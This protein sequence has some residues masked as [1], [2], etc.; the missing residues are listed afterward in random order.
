MDAE[1][2]I[3]VL[4]GGLVGSACTLAL[5]RQGLK[6]ALVERGSAQENIADETLDD[7]IYA[8]TPGNAAWLRSLDVWQKL[9]PRHVC[10]IDRMQVH[11]DSD[12]ASIDFDAD[13]AHVERLGYIVESKRLQQALWNALRE[14][15]AALLTDTVCAG[16]VWQAEAAALSLA[17]GR[18]L[19]AS[20][21]VAADGADS[22]LRMQAGIEA[23]FHD[24]GQMGVVANFAS[25]LPHGNTA[26]QWFRDDGVLAWLPLPGQRISM[27]WS[28]ATARVEQLLALNAEGLAQAVAVAGG[29]ELGTLQ[30][31]NAARAFPLRLQT[32]QHLV[33]SGLALIGDAAHI[34]H[35]LAG[36]GVNLGFRDA[37]ALA[38]TLAGRNSRQRLGDIMLL[39]RYER[40]RKTD[41][42]AMRGL[43]DGL[44]RLFSSEQPGIRQARNWGLRLTERLPLLK[45]RLIRQ[46]TL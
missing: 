24:Y 12:A 19:T 27:V 11:G 45:R 6:V 16:V 39:R 8:I 36:Q 37:I 10:P 46:A 28:T 5:Q 9:E 38:Q 15:D 44:Q 30:A 42:L 31:L 14:S 29:L 32:A 34:I 35:P 17:D 43:T 33:R 25:A 21:L 2:D 1:Y 3:I 23:S 20:L 13:E 22:W 4:G 18:R 7:R 41:M 40:A 26:R